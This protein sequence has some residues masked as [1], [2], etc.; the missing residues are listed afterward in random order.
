LIQEKNDIYED[1]S[2]WL[3]SKV[4]RINKISIS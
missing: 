2:G 4:D 1:F 3:Q